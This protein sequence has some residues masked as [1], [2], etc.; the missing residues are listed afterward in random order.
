MLEDLVLKVQAN[1][2]LMSLGGLGRGCG[3]HSVVQGPTRLL[4]PCMYVY[5]AAA[6]GLQRAAVRGGGLMWPARTA[7]AQDP[8]RLCKY[9]LHLPE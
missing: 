1:R 6:K 3:R 2:V 4:Q 7:A 5:A 8:A 9:C